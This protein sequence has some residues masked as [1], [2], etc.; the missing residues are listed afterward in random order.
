MGLISRIVALHK[1][2]ARLPTPTPLDDHTWQL[3]K[4][5]GV[6]RDRMEELWLRNTTFGDPDPYA[7]FSD[8]VH[9]L[10]HERDFGTPRKQLDA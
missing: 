2:L 1:A 6:A 5:Y 8:F 3:F 4:T 10:E 9:S 7:S